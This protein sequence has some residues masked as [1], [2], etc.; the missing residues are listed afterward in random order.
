MLR[1]R[2]R[3]LL[4]PSLLCAFLGI[5][6]E[7]FTQTSGTATQSVQRP[8]RMDLRLADPSQ[9]RGLPLLDLSSGKAD[10]IDP[11][12]ARAHAYDVPG[13]PPLW[14]SSTATEHSPPTVWARRPKDTLP[15]NRSDVVMI[16]T[17]TGAHAYLS[18]SR[19][20]VYSVFNVV[21]VQ[22]LKG[23]SLLPTGSSSL[24][25]ERSGGLVK[26]P[27]GKVI[28]AGVEKL[29]IPRNGVQYVLF[30]H[31]VRGAGLQ[32]ITAFKIATSGVIPLDDDGGMEVRRYAGVSLQAL[33][34]DIQ[35]KRQSV[36]L[37]S[38]K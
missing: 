25:I 19:S 36:A 28:A 33:L 37:E 3:L 12:S 4:V 31:I 34:S 6:V 30:L 2:F 26:Y 32:I 24:E 10:D 11:N 15:W 5:G 16:A 7:G 22:V 20:V 9:M 35:K 13:L 14:D 29:G 8:S 38:G 17:V 27:S 1:I 21:P 23:Q 18:S